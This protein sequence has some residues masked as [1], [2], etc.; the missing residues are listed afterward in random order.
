MIRLVFHVHVAW[1]LSCQPGVKPSV[2]K[3][4]HVTAGSLTY[5][6]KT[7]WNALK[8]RQKELTLSYKCLNVLCQFLQFY[9]FLQLLCV[10]SVSYCPVDFARFV[11][12]CIC[13]SEWVILHS[14]P[15]CI[16]L[17]SLS[18]LLITP[19]PSPGSSLTSSCASSYQRR[20]LRSQTTSLENG[21]FPRWWDAANY[22]C[23]QTCIRYIVF[24]EHI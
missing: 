23:T 20:W 13:P 9:S 7:F 2:Q 6:R 17:A 24:Q 19:F 8:E 22:T 1:S 14:A 16:P 18:S 5:Q 11:R 21:V 15:S 3:L 12:Y 10:V 4:Q